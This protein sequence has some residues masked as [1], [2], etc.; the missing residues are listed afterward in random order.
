M[1]YNAETA[2]VTPYPEDKQSM[3]LKTRQSCGIIPVHKWNSGTYDEVAMYHDESIVCDPDTTTCPQNCQGNDWTID[4]E[5]TSLTIS[6]DGDSFE[7]RCTFKRSFA[8]GAMREMPF[9][10]KLNWMAGYNIYKTDQA[11]WRYVYGYSYQSDLRN[12]EVVMLAN[13]I[14]QTIMLSLT[15]AATGLSLIF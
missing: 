4:L 5:K 13:A 2:N 3:K 8:E 9:D 10:E 6:E 12:K 15:V 11:M 1:Q 7:A 14:S